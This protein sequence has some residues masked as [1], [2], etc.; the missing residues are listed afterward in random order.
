MEKIKNKEIIPIKVKNKIKKNVCVY[1]GCNNPLML[2]V[3]H[4]K[5]K[6]RGGKDDE[7]NLQSC[8]WVC[9]QLKGSL[10]DKEFK[11]YMKALKIL[12]KLCKIKIDFPNELVLKPNWRH[13]PGF[14]FTKE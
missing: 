4:K 9:N 2:T 10:T 6:R 12:F 7:K 3:D 1:C 13:H 8:C 14:R 5:P 11:Q